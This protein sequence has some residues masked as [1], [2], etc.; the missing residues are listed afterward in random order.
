[1]TISVLALAVVALV[2]GATSLAAS[3][4]VVSAWRIAPARVAIARDPLALLA[5]RLFPTGCALLVS[6]GLV[7]PAYLVR[8]PQA[9]GETVGAALLAFLALLSI[10]V[11][12][13]AAR[14][15][16]ALRASS[17]LLAGYLRRGRRI[18]VAGVSIPVYEVEAPFPAIAVAGVFRPRLLIA[19]QLRATLSTDELASILAHESSHVSRSDNL[20]Q[21]L[22]RSAPDWLP[23][24]SVAAEMQ[25]AWRDA[26]EKSADDEAVGSDPAAALTLAAALVSV[27]RITPRHAGRLLLANAVGNPDVVLERVRRLVSGRPRTSDPWLTIGSALALCPFGLVPALAAFT[28]SRADLLHSAYELAEALIQ[29]LL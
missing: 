24:T 2:H 9:S 12:L 7:L 14:G 17:R 18:S 26:T 22:M 13:G 4:A 23:F 10:P 21:L 27:A 5:L 29:A 19:A 16:L 3:A 1:M 8:E 11:L 20:R 15:G 25:E 28:L 6:L